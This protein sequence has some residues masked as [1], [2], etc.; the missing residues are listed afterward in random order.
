M[1]PRKGILLIKATADEV[2]PRFKTS[3]DTVNSGEAFVCV[4]QVDAAVKRAGRG[5]RTLS[6]I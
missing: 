5:K 4:S 2:P 6:G 1:S 3:I